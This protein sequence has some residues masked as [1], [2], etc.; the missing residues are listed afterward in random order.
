M[1][2]EK[3]VIGIVAEFNP[4]HE[5]HAYLLREARER[6][7]AAYVVIVMS[8]DFVQRGEPAIL[9]K[10]DRTRAAISAG[11][12][13]VLQLPVMFSTAAAEDFAG[14]AVAVLERTGICDCLLFGSESADPSL[15][16]KTADFLAA[17]QQC[18]QV[19]SENEQIYEQI[20]QFRQLLRQRQAEGLSFP[21]ARSMALSEVLA[22]PADFLPNDVLGIEY[23]K[24]IQLQKAAMTPCILQRDAL[25]KSAHSIR[26]EMLASRDKSGESHERYRKPDDFSDMLSYQLLRLQREGIPFSDFQDVSAELS[27]SIARQCREKHSFT[28]RIELLKTKNLTHARISRGLLHILLEI[29]REDYEKT[30]KRGF[31]P[32]LRV[33][34]VSRAGRELLSKLPEPLMISPARTLKQYPMLAENPSLQADFFASALWQQFSAQPHNDFTEKLIVL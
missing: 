10:Y 3:R 31:L 34:G 12:D 24:A 30:K 7:G 8:G 18:Q 9:S 20:L 33:L 4:F 27:Q 15:L 21:K 22:L 28:E 19:V 26:R 11:A 13:L 14:A 17:E 23:L 1:Y 2:Q 32:C 29:R 25:L 6:F 16:Q 5:G